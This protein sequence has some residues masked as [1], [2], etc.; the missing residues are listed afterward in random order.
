MDLILWRHA[1][2]E[3]GMPDLDRKLTPRGHKQAARMARWLSAQLPERFRLLS[4]PAAR[5]RQTATALGT[6]MH[7]DERL[8]P[9]GN[10]R[11]LLAACGWG[12][13]GETVVVVGHQ[14]TLGRVAALALTGRETDWRLRKGA[15]CWLSQGPR[16]GAI[17]KVLIPP[18]MLP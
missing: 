14:P 17:L 1:E 3:D 12:G 2:A 10:A 13:D 7:V 4:S 18:D 6:R 5:A 15:I 8:A 11:D 16:P 9:G